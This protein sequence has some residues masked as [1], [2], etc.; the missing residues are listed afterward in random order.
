MMI[1]GQTQ[2]CMIFAILIPKKTSEIETLPLALTSIMLIT[3][4]YASTLSV[5]MPIPFI[6]V[7][8]LFVSM[9][10]SSKSLPN[11]TIEE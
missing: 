7:L 10:I 4:I 8:T 3:R 6:N 1:K 5:N 2:M 9:S 11:E